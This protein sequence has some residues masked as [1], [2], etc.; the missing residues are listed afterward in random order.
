MNGNHWKNHLPGI[1]KV[2]PA[3]LFAIGYLDT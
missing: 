2:M 1:A 3:I